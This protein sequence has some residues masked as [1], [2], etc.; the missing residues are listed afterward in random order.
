MISTAEKWIFRQTGLDL[1]NCPK[2]FRDLLL[3]FLETT[4]FEFISEIELKVSDSA[5]R[6]AQKLWKKKEKEIE[7]IKSEKYIFASEEELYIEG[8][9]YNEAQ[10]QFDIEEENRQ[11]EKSKEY[12][13]AS[14]EERKIE[15]TAYDEAQ[16]QFEIEK[17]NRQKEK[18][19]KE[20]VFASKKE[21]YIEGR[22]YHKTQKEWEEKEGKKKFLNKISKSNSEQKRKGKQS[23]NVL[24]FK[25]VK[26]IYSTCK[27]C[28]FYGKF[29]ILTNKKKKTK[30][31]KCSKCRAKF[32]EGKKRG[33]FI[34]VS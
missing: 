30:H 26:T 8:K 7:E 2:T 10:I 13:F 28:G 24:P 12:V 9:A 27:N 14:E 6:K 16:K 34:Q 11:E 19:I 21:R 23:S 25:K 1:N 3:F 29:K 17:K 32:E 33:Q 31:Y 22:A 5:Y 18:E 15:G 4:K 20:Y